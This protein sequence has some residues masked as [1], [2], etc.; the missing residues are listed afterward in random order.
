MPVSKV[1]PETFKG[2]GRRF[3][4]PKAHIMAKERHNSTKSEKQQKTA[5]KKM[6]TR[7]AKSLA[8]LS[9]MGINYEFPGVVSKVI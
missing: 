9:T 3:A 5:L 8:K 7:K 4:K 6:K 2:S 1:H